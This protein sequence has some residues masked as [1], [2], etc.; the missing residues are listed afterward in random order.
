MS[1]VFYVEDN[2]LLPKSFCNLIEDFVF[3]WWVLCLPDVWPFILEPLKIPTS[4]PP[5]L[6]KTAVK[7]LLVLE[8]VNQTLNFFSYSSHLVLL[9][10]QQPV[11]P[12][13]LFQIVGMPT[14][15]RFHSL[16]RSQQFDRRFLLHQLCPE[17]VSQWRRWGNSVE[18][19]PF[20]APATCFGWPSET[21]WY[22]S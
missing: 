16:W 19:E 22:C 17:A 21:F 12:Q 5:V 11:L 8:E 1:F 13:F 2:H 15:S 7:T 4:D 10:M 9:S 20:S 6:P 18:K 14:T 3:S